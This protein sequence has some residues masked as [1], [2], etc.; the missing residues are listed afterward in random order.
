M[1]KTLVII[2]AAAV[3]LFIA[4][5]AFAPHPDE[6]EATDV[7]TGSLAG[8]RI[9]S[10]PDFGFQMQ[11]P[12]A[13]EVHDSYFYHALGP[14][15]EIPG[16]FF[17]V[18]AGL[19]QGTNLSSDSGISVEMLARAACVPADFLPVSTAGQ[20]V[21]LGQDEY[22]YA[23][24]SGAGAGNRYDEAVYIRKNRDVCYGIRFFIHSTAIQNYDPGT[25]REF[26][27]EGLL[28]T[29]KTIASTVT[30]I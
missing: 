10:N 17:G 7:G 19:A 28:S 22:T 23:T 3:A 24:S 25:V 29:F 9:Y 27:R 8:W 4:W 1:R 11:I 18:P 30:F 6:P 5:F 16:I 26:D 13:F 20:K 15:K 21:M 14:G 12:E 2:G